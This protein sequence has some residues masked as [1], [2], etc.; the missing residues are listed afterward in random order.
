MKYTNFGGCIPITHNHQ[1]HDENWNH[2]KLYHYCS[3]GVSYNPKSLKNV[4]RMKSVYFQAIDSSKTQKKF[5]K[6]SN[7]FKI[8]DQESNQ[9]DCI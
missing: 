6:V 3:H 7:I 9:R 4:L 8:W 5:L 2:S 1:K